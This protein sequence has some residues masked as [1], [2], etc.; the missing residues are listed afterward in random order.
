[1]P[2]MAVLLALVVLAGGPTYDVAHV[3]ASFRAR[4][5]LPL[6]RFAAASTS[7]V[8]A[9]RSR[10]H[11]TRRFG[12]FQIFVFRPAVAKRMARVFTHGTRP[13]GRGIHWVPDRAGGWIA[14]SLFPSNL[15][16]G[17][18]PPAGARLVDERWRRLQA[19]ARA[20]RP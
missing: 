8:T 3:Q 6:V 19:V 17:W 20:L 12:E 7:D 14:V 16:V 18:F 13:D 15:C 2:P 4:T 11:K 9:L 10:P 5:G 1:M